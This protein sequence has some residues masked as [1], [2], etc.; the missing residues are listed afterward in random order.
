MSEE[1]KKKIIKKIIKLKAPT[2]TEK[3]VEEKKTDEKAAEVKIP[4]ETRAKGYKAKGDC[5]ACRNRDASQK[6][7]IP[8]A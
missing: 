8:A 4:A 6:V 1:Q 5:K 2:V 3:K 7:R